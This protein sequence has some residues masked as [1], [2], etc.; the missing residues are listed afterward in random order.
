MNELTASHVISL[1]EEVEK[2]SGNGKEQKNDHFA[3]ILKTANRGRYSRKRTQSGNI[4]IC[5]INN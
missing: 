5:D 3:L 4:V 2:D 1:P